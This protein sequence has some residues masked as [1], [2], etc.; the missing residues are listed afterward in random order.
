MISLILLE[1]A[2]AAVTPP[3]PGE[4]YLVGLVVV[5]RVEL[6]HLGLL[7]VLESARQVICPKLLA[8]LLT[9]H[10]PSHHE[11][12]ELEPFTS[13]KHLAITKR[14][15]KLARALKRCSQITA[16]K[17]PRRARWRPCPT[18]ANFGDRNN[19]HGLGQLDVE[20]AGAQEPE[21]SQSVQSLCVAQLLQHCPQLEDLRILFRGG[22]A[23]VTIL[24]LRRSGRVV[25]V[26]ILGIG[27]HLL[28]GS[29]RH[30]EGG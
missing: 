3:Q 16:L 26:V 11:R 27:G 13:S 30:D 29:I 15:L 2:L 19:I 28:L 17:R 6:E 14:R 18:R 21:E 8:P 25:V 10:E 5:L 24:L 22:V 4:T 23:G 12:H 20:L 7:G 9:V 1:Q